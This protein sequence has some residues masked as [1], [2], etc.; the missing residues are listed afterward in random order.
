[1]SRGAR[2]REVFDVAVRQPA[3]LIFEMLGALHGAIDDPL[4]DTAIV[5][6][7]VPQDQVDGRRDGAV[8]T[9]I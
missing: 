4:Y 7:N 2:E 3:V 6:V 1:M 5:G 9:G 8:D